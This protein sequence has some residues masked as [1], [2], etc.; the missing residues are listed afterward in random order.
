[1]PFGHRR[2]T[3]I[4]NF[5]IHPPRRPYSLGGHTAAASGACAAQPVAR[6]GNAV[7][8]EIPRMAHHEVA[9]E[10][11]AE[12]SVDRRGLLRGFGA[13]AAALAA[14]SAGGLAASTTP[15]LAAGDADIFN[16][17]LNLEYLEAEFYLRAATGQGLAAANVTGTGTQG[18]VTGGALVPFASPAIQQYAQRIAV[19]EQAHVLFIRDVLG[20]AAVAEPTINL[21]TSFTNLAIAAGLIVSGQTFNPFADQV[22][23]LLGASIFEDVGVTAYAG[24]ASSIANPNYLTAAAGILAT[25]AYH[26]GSIRTLLADIGAGVAFDAISNL[27][28]VLSAAVGGAGTQAEQGI[29]I[30]GNNYNFVANDINGLAFRRTAAQVLNIVYGGGAASN[31]L[32]FPNKLNGNIS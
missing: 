26:S 6:V 24:A 8:R 21:S 18:T 22:S 1:L 29:L 9:R 25:E 7:Q 23:F 15:A 11:D 20:S 3:K 2:S 4:I 12:A 13:S 19:D 10:T 14:I 5:R 30:T 17:A 27:R 28:G 32:F 31:Y 16:F